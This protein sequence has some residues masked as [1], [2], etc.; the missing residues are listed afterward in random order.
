[1]APAKPAEVLLLRSR[2]TRDVIN[3]IGLSCLF[4][5]VLT[6]LHRRKSAS[7]TLRVLRQLEI[8]FAG[9]RRDLGRQD[10]SLIMLAEEVIESQGKDAYLAA[11]KR[12]ACNIESSDALRH[13]LYFFGDA[14]P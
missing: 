4:G 6:C 3:E 14:C 5:A 2:V 1:M 13:C 11:W 9:A 10:I 8:A 7:G 12:P